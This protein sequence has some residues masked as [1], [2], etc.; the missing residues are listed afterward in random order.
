MKLGPITKLDRMNTA[1]SKKLAMA[2]CRETVTSF[3][4][5]QYMA[6]LKQSGS[7]IPDT[8]SVKLTFDVSFCK[9]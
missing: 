3:L 7:Q 5:F 2:T 8:W 6:N 4:I 1:T 9:K